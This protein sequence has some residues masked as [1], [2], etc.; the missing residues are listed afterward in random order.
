[1][2][3]SPGLTSQTLAG[4]CGRAANPSDRP[5]K[6]S[7]FT[8][9]APLRG[10]RVTGPFSGWQ[11]IPPSAEVAA[12]ETLSS[13]QPLLK[14]SHRCFLAPT[15]P[16]HPKPTPFILKNNKSPGGCRGAGG[17]RIPEESRQSRELVQPEHHTCRG[18]DVPCLRAARPLSSHRDTDG[19][20]A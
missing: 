5:A 20:L 2:S 15:P 1:M 14:F 18:T 4:W 9:P 11:E 3:A 13:A 6:A 10:D 7:G 17:R 16:P 8:P 12:V 19:S